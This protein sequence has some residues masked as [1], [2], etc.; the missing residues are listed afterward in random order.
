VAQN[1]ERF[2]QRRLQRTVLPGNFFH[3]RLEQP[4]LLEGRFITDFRQ[5]DS[6]IAPPQ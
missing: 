3:N 5:S 4:A 1:F 6:L 2:E